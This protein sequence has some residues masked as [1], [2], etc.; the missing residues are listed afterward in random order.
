[1]ASSAA[2]V[3]FLGAGKMAAAL[4]KG[5]LEG[6]AVA[7]SAQISASC[8]KSDAHL[9]E[10]FDSLGART[11]HSNQELVDSSDVLLVAVKPNVMSDVLQEVKP[12]VK[13]KLVV[14][15]AAGIKIQQLES[16]LETSTKVINIIEEMVHGCI[17]IFAFK[18]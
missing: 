8:P 16:D 14:S 15:I 10:T 11:M 5:F 2:R 9:L 7:A 12:F 17:N 3:G 1:M 6:G 4:A 18:I 13:D